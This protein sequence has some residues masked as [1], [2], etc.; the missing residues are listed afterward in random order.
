[1]GD[2]W[3]DSVFV[4]DEIGRSAGRC[5]KDALD[6]EN[7]VERYNN[8]VSVLEEYIAT[9]QLGMVETGGCVWY[10][11]ENAEEDAPTDDSMSAGDNQENEGQLSP[12]LGKFRSLQNIVLVDERFDVALG[13]QS[14]I[15]LVLNAASNNAGLSMEVVRGVQNCFQRLYRKARNQGCEQL[16][17]VFQ[18]HAQNFQTL[19]K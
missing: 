7:H 5:Q 13:C 19:L 16:A 10:E 11:S 3:S 1:M 2:A 8:E 9:L 18:D 14:A 12:L 6:F 15:M 4:L 17:N